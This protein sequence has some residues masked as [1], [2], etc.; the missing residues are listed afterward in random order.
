MQ[1]VAP[2]HS[3]TIM[4][5]LSVVH[6]ALCLVMLHSCIK[7]RILIAWLGWDV[8]LLGLTADQEGGRPPSASNDEVVLER[9]CDSIRNTSE[10]YSYSAT[11]VKRGVVV[12]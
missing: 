9:A 1:A 10:F 2:H 3:E 8:L 4:I 11:S 7:G 6:H 5:R 12:S